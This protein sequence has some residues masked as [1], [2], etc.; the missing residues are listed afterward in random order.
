[1]LIIEEDKKVKNNNLIDEKTF[2]GKYYIYPHIP[3]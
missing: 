1:L 2:T 3:F